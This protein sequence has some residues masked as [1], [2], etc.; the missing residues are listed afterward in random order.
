MEG[1]GVGGQ[2]DDGEATDKRMMVVVDGKLLMLRG[3]ANN[4]SVKAIYTKLRLKMEM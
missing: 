4:G 2:P 3:Q 1:T